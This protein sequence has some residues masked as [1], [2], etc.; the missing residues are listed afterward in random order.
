M[1]STYSNLC[2]VRESKE[3]LQKYIRKLV[4]VVFEFIPEEPRKLI[5]RSMD[6]STDSLEGWQNQEDKQEVQEL[7]G[8]TNRAN[9]I[10]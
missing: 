9:Q 7:K 4:F 2:H 8:E 10:L 3:Y 5:G 1:L 6:Y